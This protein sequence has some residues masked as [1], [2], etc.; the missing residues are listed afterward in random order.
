MINAK[1]AHILTEIHSKIYSGE[2]AFKDVDT[3]RLRVLESL[4][5]NACH[6]GMNEV[7]TYEQLSDNEKNLLNSLG[8]FTA[9]LMADGEVQGWTIRWIGGDS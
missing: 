6:H 4:I 3:F 8:Y 2:H 7:A 5:L 1:D 9:V